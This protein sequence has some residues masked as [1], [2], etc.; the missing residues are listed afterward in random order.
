MSFISTLINLLK[1]LPRDSC[2]SKLNVN[3]WRVE[4]TSTKLRGKL[5]F[6]E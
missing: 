6:V 3:Y 2:V 5:W 4:F 1:I